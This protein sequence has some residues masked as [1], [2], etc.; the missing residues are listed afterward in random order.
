MLFPEVNK[1]SNLSL[2]KKI[3]CDELTDEELIECLNI[4]NVTAIQQTILKLV[5]RKIHSKYVCDKLLE[6]SKYMDKRF[7]ILGLC[8][9][10]HLAIFALKK[11]DYTEEFRGLFEKL[12][13]EDKEQVLY[14]EQAFM[15]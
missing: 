14:L 10:G 9:L 11:L 15:N 7:K 6:Y 12:S 4:P 3:M 5:E 1:L 13:E 8:K 2:I